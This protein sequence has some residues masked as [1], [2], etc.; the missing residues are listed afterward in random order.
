MKISIRRQLILIT[1]FLIVLAIVSTSIISFSLISKDYEEKIQYNN[2]V[3]AESL[4]SNII[5][6]MQNAYM[7]NQSVAEFPGLSNLD[8]AKQTEL[9]VDT[10]K[11]YPFLQLLAIHNL[12]GEQTARSSGSLANRSERWWF[13]KFMAERKSFITTPYYSVFSESPIT[14]I[15]HGIYLNGTLTGLLM[16]DI[17]VKKL[18]QM[19]EGYNLGE[20]SYAYLLDDEGAVIAHP[21]RQ[22]VTELYNYK[23][24][25]KQV[26]VRNASGEILKDESGYEITEKVSFEVSPDLQGII[27]KVLAGNIGEG[28]YRDLNGEPYVC[29]YRAMSLP[30]S[31]KPWGL[32]VVQKKSAAMAF[33]GQATAKVI[34]VG[35]LVI[36]FSVLLTIWFSRKLTTPLLDIVHAA[37]QV[38]AGDLEVRVTTNHTANEINVLAANFNQMVYELSQHRNSLQKLVED[39]TLELGAANQEML[40]MNEE[41]TAMNETLADT[42]DRLNEENVARR[43]SEDKLLLRDRQY[44]AITGLLTQPIDKHGMEDIL[45]PIM[46]NAIQLLNGVVCYIGLFDKAGKNFYIRHGIGIDQVWIGKA[47]PARVGMKWQVYSTGEIFYVKD[48]RISP[49]RNQ[50]TCLD[51]DTS[52]VIMAPLKRA[53]KV[54]GVLAVCWLHEVHL[55]SKE[56]MESLR[57]FSDL[58]S[59]ALERDSVQREISHIAFHDTLTGLPNRASLNRYLA[60][61]MEQARAGRAAGIILFID[62]DELKTVND[63]FGHSV[64]DNIIVAASRYIIATVGKEAK[65]FR[66][67]GDEFLVVVPG[68]STRTKAEKIAD[69]AL[70]SLSKEYEAAGEKIHLSASIGVLVYPE[71]GD[72]AEDILKKA[73]TA[74]YA[75]KKAGRNC[76]RFYEPILL[77]E[78]YEKMTLTNGL[79]RALE[80]NEFSLY[81]QPQ[82][83]AEGKQILGFEALLRWQ[84]QEYGLVTPDRFIPVAEQSGL[85]V[86]IGRWVLQ[87]ACR[88]ARRLVDIGR[89]DIRVAVNISARQ[90]MSETL[91]ADVNSSIEAVGIKPGQIEIEITESVFIESMED[92]IRKLCQLRNLG[93]ELAL[94]DFGTGYSSLTYLRSLPVGILK[95]DK[96]F[97][98]KIISDQTQLQVVET[99]IDLG[100]H[101]SL[102]V[103]AEGVETT[104]QLQILRAA[105]CNRIQGY[106]FSKPLTESAAMDMLQE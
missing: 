40:A 85:I 76:W 66:I 31:T 67:G 102:E 87:E 75:A 95:I 59:V 73:D 30:G 5:Q 33:M 9:L 51:P 53:G 10:T 106:V 84:S 18:Q 60:D 20:G 45:G 98:D 99:I 93:V 46:H 103:V 94:D 82:F 91:V 78:A 79:R 25:T 21:D 89:K 28:E 49:I 3:M 50:D 83:S 19:V 48:Y 1:C 11:R 43:Q 23:T 90:L 4:A 81:Y 100:H 17:E 34:F 63:N 26:L 56:D 13:K 97:I 8:A 22:Q 88:F 71:D 101:M 77:E 105:G 27:R 41:L 29:T 32:I 37:N 86:P 52:S 58:A 39:R 72:V 104:E 64:G 2:S 12:N 65:V 6:F 68:V 14:T 57:Q 70:R 44:R 15:V 62:I 74:M 47:R 16:A 92:T 61:E 69:K 7:V 38:K 55:L 24:M 36:V 80:R 96:L 42:N 35:L 54:I